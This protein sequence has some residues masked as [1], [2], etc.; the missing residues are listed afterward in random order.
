MYSVKNKKKIMMI[1][2]L[3]KQYNTNQWIIKENEKNYIGMVS[4][5]TLQLT[6]KKPWGDA[7]L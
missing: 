7:I 5:S 1:D 3:V 4:D 2:D 6:F